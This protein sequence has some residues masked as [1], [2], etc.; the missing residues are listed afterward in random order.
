[1][2]F[3]DQTEG[4]FSPPPLDGLLKVDSMVSRGNLVCCRSELVTPSL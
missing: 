2:F 4:L 3:K 1:M